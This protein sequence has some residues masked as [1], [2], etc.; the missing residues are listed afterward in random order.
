MRNWIRHRHDCFEPEDALIIATHHRSTI[1]LLSISMLHVVTAG[2]IS[3]P[4]VD[5]YPT[6][7]VAIGVFNCTEHE[8]RFALRIVGYQSPISLC[9]S[10]VRMEWT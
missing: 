7:W 1:G 2:A 6:D 9:M 8:T 10:V 3:L 5:L 4:N